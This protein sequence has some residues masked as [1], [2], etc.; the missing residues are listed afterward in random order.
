[1]MQLKMSYSIINLRP[2]IHAD[3]IV[4][5]EFGNDYKI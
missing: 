2:F 1:M 4:H 3:L 5:L